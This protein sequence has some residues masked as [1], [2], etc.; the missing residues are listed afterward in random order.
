[1]HKMICKGEI[2]IF[3]ARKLSEIKISIVG[4]DFQTHLL[5]GG[6]VEADQV[7][8][9]CSGNAFAYFGCITVNRVLC[10]PEEEFEIVLVLRGFELF[11]DIDDCP[12][13]R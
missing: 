2:K 11:E 10:E 3:T 12:V 8:L 4:R 6:V 1:M 5:V 13:E 7:A 9:Y